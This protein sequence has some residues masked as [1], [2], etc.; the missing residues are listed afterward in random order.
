[1]KVSFKNTFGDLAGYLWYQQR[2][3]TVTLILLIGA[4]FLAFQSSR[5]AIGQY[6]MPIIIMSWFMTTAILFIGMLLFTFLLTLISAISKK[7]K[8]FFADK[9]IELTETNIIGE[10]PYG[11]S[12]LAW[13]IVQHL[14]HT[15]RLILIYTSK[16]NAITVPRRAFATQQDW[17]AFYNFVYS[18][19]RN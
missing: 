15:K 18:H 14:K 17:D 12:E 1:M 6:S 7:N 9:T 13:N 8:T 11:R 10:S 5:H 19:A 16:S 2:R 3:S 4:G